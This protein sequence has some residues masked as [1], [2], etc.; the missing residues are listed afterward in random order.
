MAR[1]YLSQISIEGFRGVNNEKT[2]PPAALVTAE[3]P[4]DS[5]TVAPEIAVPAGSATEP[6]AGS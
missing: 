2:Y 6:L 3:A 1:Y 4:F 5:N